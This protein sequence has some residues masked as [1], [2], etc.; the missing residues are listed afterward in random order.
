M[1]I[2]NISNDNA[3]ITNNLWKTPKAYF[4]LKNSHG[5]A[6]EFLRGLWTIL[7][8]AVKGIGQPC[9]TGMYEIKVVLQAHTK[10]V[11]CAFPVLKAY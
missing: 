7:A 6:K 5:Q 4:A 3:I 1:I 8:R 9:L 11:N 2:T 10:T